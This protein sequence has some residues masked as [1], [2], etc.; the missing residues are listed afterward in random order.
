M[1]YEDFSSKWMFQKPSLASSLLK[2]VAPLR[3]WEISLR[4]G[5]YNA[6]TLWPCSGPWGQGIYIGYHQACRDRLRRY[7]FGSL[8]DRCD[9]SLL[10]HLIE[11]ALYLLPVLNG[12]LPLGVLD[13]GNTRVGPDGIGPRHIPYGIEGGQE[14]PLQDDYVLDHGGTARGSHLSQLHLEDWLSFK[15]RHVGN[16]VFEGWYGLWCSWG[17]SCFVPL[18]IVAG[19][20]KLTLRKDVAVFLEPLRPWG[21]GAL[22]G[23]ARSMRGLW[24]LCIWQY[25]SSCL[26]EGM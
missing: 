16:M 9:C 5:F 24:K 10:D 20:W 14:G 26:E 8:R 19:S 25:F 11:S 12:Y 2:H 3:W 18:I 4:V 17:L 7:P 21:W 1:R 23:W 15:V 6:L 13:R 22:H